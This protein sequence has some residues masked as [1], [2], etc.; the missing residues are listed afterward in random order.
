MCFKEHISR[1]RN[2]RA[3]R[4]HFRRERKRWIFT[5][6]QRKPPKFKAYRFLEVVFHLDF[7]FLSCYSHCSAVVR[8]AAQS[9]SKPHSIF[10]R[11]SLKQFWSFMTSN[12]GLGDAESTPMRYNLLSHNNGFTSTPFPSSQPSHSVHSYSNLVHEI[13]KKRCGTTQWKR[14]L[15]KA[16]ACNRNNSGV[17]FSKWYM[18]LIELHGRNAIT[19]FLQHVPNDTSRGIS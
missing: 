9:K 19:P 7:R 11:E 5:L 1:T 18:R 17:Q 12:Q 13:W 15:R 8:R 3:L 10:A 2:K 16:L 4:I 14:G 6:C